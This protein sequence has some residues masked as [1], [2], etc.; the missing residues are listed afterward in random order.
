[1]DSSTSKPFDCKEMQILRQTGLELLQSSRLTPRHPV[2][3]GDSPRK[4]SSDFYTRTNEASFAC[5]LLNLP[6]RIKK[7]RE[8]PRS[9]GGLIPAKGG[10]LSRARFILGD[11][12][13]G[14]ALPGDL[15]RS[16]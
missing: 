7:F 14:A 3:I 10:P 5:H 9:T 2:K 8:Q 13:K 6:P 1:M 11:R 15:T 4:I 12:R 16:E